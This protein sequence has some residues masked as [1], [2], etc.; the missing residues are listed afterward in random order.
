[1]DW[2]LFWVMQ[3]WMALYE[4]PGVGM[5]DPSRKIAMIASVKRILAR[6]SGV[7]NARA[8]AVSTKILLRGGAV[9]RRPA[10]VGGAAGARQA[11]AGPGGAHPGPT[12]RGPARAPA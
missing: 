7:R 6:R 3:V 12:S 11:A 1:M 9:R 10:Q 5:V 2:S 4:T 8:N